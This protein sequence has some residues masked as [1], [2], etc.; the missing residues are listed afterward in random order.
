MATQRLSDERLAEI[1][2]DYA[3]YIDGDCNSITEAEAIKIIGQLL[4]EIERLKLVI[5]LGG[6]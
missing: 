3:S 1:R 5:E 2:Q 6:K 4:P